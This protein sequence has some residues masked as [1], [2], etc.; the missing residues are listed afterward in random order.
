MVPVT[1]C[2]LL[3][4]D[5]PA[6]ARQCLESI[7]QHC[8]P[9]Q[10]LL[11][12]GT[13]AIGSRTREYLNERQLAGDLD[14]WIDSPL[15]LNKCPMMRRMFAEVDTEFIWWFD[16]DSFLDSR[17]VFERWIGGAL[18]SPGDVAAWGQLAVCNDDGFAPDLPDAVKFVR[19]APWYRGL[20]PPSWRPGGKGELDFNGRGCGDGRWFF[21][22]GGCWLIRTEVVRAL[23][24]PDR[25]LIKMGDDVLLGE[26]IRQHGWR[27]INLGSQGVAINTVK[28]RGDPGLQPRAAKAPVAD[29]V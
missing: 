1:I 11:T 16:D 27:T 6:L 19:E 14:R 21:I 2:V 25:R 26:A 9:E 7:R 22:V 5:H 15:N 10:Y 23:D 28:R 4:G 20:P 13:N 18:Q 17:D 29:V 3:Y 24:W 12:V 8:P